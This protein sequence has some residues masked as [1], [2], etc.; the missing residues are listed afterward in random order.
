LPGL[1]LNHDPPNLCILS[2]WDY[3]HEPQEPGS[4]LLLIHTDKL[5]IHLRVRKTVSLE[6]NIR[7]QGENKKK[8]KRER[9]MQGIVISTLQ[10]FSSPP[11]N[12]QCRSLK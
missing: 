6:K 3:R 10:D 11:E 5:K 7:I 4:T 12:L 1:A 8:K 2:S 9:E